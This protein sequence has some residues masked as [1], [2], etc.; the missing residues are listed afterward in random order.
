MMVAG[1]PSR[2]ISNICLKLMH[3]LTTGGNQIT[4]CS[5]LTGGKMAFINYDPAYLLILN[6]NGSK[7]CKIPLPITFGMDVTCIDQNTA[8]VTSPVD[9]FIQLVDINTGK[10][11][12]RI[13]TNTTCSGITSINGM[14][15]FCSIG[16]GLRKVDLKDERIVEIVNF[17][18]G[19]G[20]RVTSFNT[21]LYYTDSNR[22]EVVCCDINGTILWTFTDTSVLKRPLSIAVDD[23]GNV[24]VVDCESANV[25]VISPDGKEYRQLLSNA[26]RLNTPYALHYDRQARQLLVGNFSTSASLYSVDYL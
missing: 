22:N 2:S 10:T 4:G 11:V 13:N 20:S 5:I 17:R 12:K 18:A 23:Y 16:E 14:L 24:Y 8:V 6:A 21:R 7:N 25:V 1:G 26:Y 3:N 9:K 19:T 15:V